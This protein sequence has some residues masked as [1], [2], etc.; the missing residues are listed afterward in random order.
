[1][2]FYQ[3]WKGFI[4]EFNSFGEFLQA[5]FYRILGGIVGIVILIFLVCYFYYYGEGEW[6]ELT[7][8]WELAKSIT[9]ID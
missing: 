6:P 3:Y 9:E 1:M 8:L 4:W 5:I 7:P 2:R